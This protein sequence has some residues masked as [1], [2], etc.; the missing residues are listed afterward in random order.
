MVPLQLYAKVKNSSDKIIVWQNP[1]P[2][3]TRFCRPIRF[4]FLRETTE[5]SKN[6][7]EHVETQIKNLKRTVSACEV[8]QLTV[9][10]EMLVTMIDGKVCNAITS[11]ASAQTC[12]VCGATP[13]EMNDLEK[14]SKR[15]VDE[16]SLQFALSP[17]HAWIRSFE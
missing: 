1:R 7:N 3:S 15:I 2:S 4:Q 17:L 13:K 9:S 11:T 8:G 6:E 14:V 12:Y 10:H 5:I 16:K